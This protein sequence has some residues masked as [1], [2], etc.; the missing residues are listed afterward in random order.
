MK[1][2]LLAG[3]TAI[4]L[5]AS[6][7]LLPQQKVMQVLKSTP[8]YKGIAPRL[9][10]G[11][12][13]KG[14]QK[15]GFYIITVYDKKGSGSFFVTKDLKYTILGNV[16]DNKTARPI[17]PDYPLEKFHGNKD[18]VKNGVLFTVGHGPKD[19]Y[20]VTDPQCPFCRQF[21]KY[22]KEYKLGEKYTMHIIFLP[23]P[24]HHHSKAMID[25][26]LNGKT[27]AEKAKRF[28]ATL[29][30]SNAWQK[31]HPTAE[32]K[33]NVNKQIAKSLKAVEELGARGTPT[34]YDSNMN[35]MDRSKVFSK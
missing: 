33:A 31:F 8:I 13:V 28:T 27:N 9:S 6:D 4:S 21:E 14:V 18:I 32:E 3:L 20:I 1:K 15:D 11:V 24:F 34:I 23:L 16:I 10:K 17:R 22:A 25:Y 19:I 26:I 29:S 30:G 7:K 2:L 35:E 12:K 5:M